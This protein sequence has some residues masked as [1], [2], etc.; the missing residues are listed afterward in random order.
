MLS[1]E[2]ALP[3]HL[4]MRHGGPALVFVI[5]VTGCSGADSSQKP[6]VQGSASSGSTV[7]MG[8]V[9]SSV[10]TGTA[11]AGTASATTGNAATA[12]NTSGTANSTSSGATGQASSSTTGAGGS[13][14]PATTMTS[15]TGL[16]TTGTGAG[17]AAS[18]A[19]A[20]A[21]TGGASEHCP[22]DAT[23]CS[24][25]EENALPEGAVYK[26]NG[27]PATPWTTDFEVDST[28]FHTGAASLRVRPSGEGSGAYKML[29]VPTPGAAFWVRFYL[30][31]DVELGVMDHNV[32]AAAAGSDDPNE[33]VFVEFAEDVG[34]SFNSH[35]VVRW[36]EGYG[37]LDGGGTNP[38]SLPADAW[39][40]I[41]IHYDGSAR[42]QQLYIAG[43]L[44][45][46][47]QDYPAGASAFTTFKFGY[48]ALHGTVR[49]TWYDD[50]A[51][52]ANRI[53]CL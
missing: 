8:G 27:D 39:H 45:I 49:N 2:S 42:A 50:V 20:T 29:A 26:L 22:S 25:F 48:N 18:T 51:V 6:E 35:D 40:C 13:G 14:T 44:Q 15:A 10:T 11:S 3:A 53:G 24:S 28:E 33:S 1:F 5:G 47:A 43:A 7:M 17:G 38:F 4:A 46:D 37:R 52:A 31:S 34:L 41:E 36:P 19:T 32:F 23:F 9:T 21:T 16:G 30:R 12:T